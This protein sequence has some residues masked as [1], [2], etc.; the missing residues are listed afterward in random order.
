MTPIA[1][2]P[3]QGTLRQC[4]RRIRYIKLS[5]IVATNSI[6]RPFSRNLDLFSSGRA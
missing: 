4:V 5:S 6:T 1:G 2:Y 3:K